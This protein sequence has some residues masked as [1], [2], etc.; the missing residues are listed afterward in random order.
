MCVCVLMCINIHTCP[1]NPSLTEIK[2]TLTSYFYLIVAPIIT[3]LEKLNY[4][5]SLVKA[6]TSLSAGKCHV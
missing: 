5:T 2:I 1:V 4:I 3:V 6:R